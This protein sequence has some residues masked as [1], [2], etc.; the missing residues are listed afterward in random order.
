MKAGLIRF[1]AFREQYRIIVLNNTNRNTGQRLE[2]S[3]SAFSNS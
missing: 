3:V 1:S 2:T